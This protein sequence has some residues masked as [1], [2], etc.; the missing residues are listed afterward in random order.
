MADS[1][2]SLLRLKKEHIKPAAELMARAFQDYPLS[3]YFIPDDSER[4]RKQPLMFQSMIRHG[5]LFGEVYATSPKLEGV[6]IWFPSDKNHWALWN[7]IRSRRFL[8]PF[9]V[10]I[11]AVARQKAFGEYAASVRKRC[12]PSRHWYLQLLGVDP[13]YQGKGYASMLLKS[14]FG[15]ID[16]EGLPGFLE[17]Q[18]E[19]NVTLYEHLGFRVVEEGIVPGSDVKSWAMVRENERK[20]NI[21]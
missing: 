14:M 4:R 10:G 21:K 12:V 15:R 7:N 5:L 20:T 8:I 6:A 13:A 16:K 11:G 19:K 18:A 9:I 17:T 1:L 2:N 3:A